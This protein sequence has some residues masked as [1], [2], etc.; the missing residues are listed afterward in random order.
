MYK[1]SKDRMSRTVNPYQYFDDIICINLESRPDKRKVTE[2]TFKNCNIPGRFQTVYKHDRGGKY[3]CFDSHIQ[4]IKRAY[5]NGD[6][7]III[8]EDDILK[9]HTYSLEHID[10]VVQFLKNNDADILFL[11]FFPWTLSASSPVEFLLSEAVTPNIIR[12]SPLATHAY[13]ITRKAMKILLST[14]HDFI[15]TEHYD[16]FLVDS[17]LKSYCYV[18]MLFEQRLCMGSDNSIDNVLELLARK[19]GCGV[20][21]TNLIHLISIVKYYFEKY[22]LQLITSTLLIVILMLLYMI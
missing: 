21:R 4:V 8:F 19:A 16:Q 20:E 12:Y 14:Y 15:D 10:N 1:Q 22:K 9:T 11:G 2:R 3:G 18:P 7:N 5:E 13:C 6:S 17:N